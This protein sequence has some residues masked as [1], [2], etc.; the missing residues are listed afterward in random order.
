VSAIT[1]PRSEE[2]RRHLTQKK[3]KQDEYID[4]D[5]YTI[6]LDDYED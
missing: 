5:E 2:E 4:E 3:F 1:F 6:V